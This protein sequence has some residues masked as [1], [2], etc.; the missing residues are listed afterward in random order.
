MRSILRFMALGGATTFVYY[1]ACLSAYKLWVA[2]EANTFIA[3]TGLI[4]Y[5]IYS[6]LLTGLWIWIIYKR[7][8]RR[9]ISL[10]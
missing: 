8:G 2:P 7:K 9:D 3:K 4:N 1:M 6:L 5:S 10:K